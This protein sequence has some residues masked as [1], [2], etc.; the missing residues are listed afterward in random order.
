MNVLII[1]TRDC[2]R[3]P[4][5]EKQLDELNISYELQLIEENP[6]IAERHDISGSP[7]LI[8]D[9][10]VLFKGDRD[11]SLPLYGEMQLLLALKLFDQGT[12]N[13]SRNKNI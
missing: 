7:N 3:R 10:T 12:R 1:A 11:F 9:D 4:L 8:V 2:K 6:E 5:L 13:L